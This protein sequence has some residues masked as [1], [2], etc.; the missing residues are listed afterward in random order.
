MQTDIQRNTTQ[1]STIPGKILYTLFL[2]ASVHATTASAEG[3]PRHT[4]LNLTPPRFSDPEIKPEEIF[5][6]NPY[7]SYVSGDNQR[8]IQRFLARMNEIVR[9]TPII[10][11]S[12]KTICAETDLRYRLLIRMSGMPVM[13]EIEKYNPDSMP[14]ISERD[15]M[16]VHSSL[17]S[18]LLNT[19]RF[20]AFNEGN[21][22]GYRYFRIAA[23]LHL[24]CKKIPWILK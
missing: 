15:Y 4:P 11:P 23:K 1:R 20:E 5:N 9:S 12:G 24:S 17:K 8:Y 22:A 18:V 21:F 7:D 2:A 13:F 3:Y 10:D 19:A 16:A 6:L 14:N